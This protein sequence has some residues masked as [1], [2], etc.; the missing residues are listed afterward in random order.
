MV[1]LPRSRPGLVGKDHV[2]THWYPARVGITGPLVFV[3]LVAL[4]WSVVYVVDVGRH[5]DYE[6][7]SHLLFRI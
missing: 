7:G 6:S 3:S 5:D 1:R 2:P 4:W